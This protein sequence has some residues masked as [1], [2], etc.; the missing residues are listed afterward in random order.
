MNTNAYYEIGAS[1]KVCEDYALSG[2]HDQLYYAIVSDGCSSS[3][4]SDVGARLLAHITKGVLVYMYEDKSILSPNFTEL[5]KELV[6]K[7]CMEAKK[8]LG[9][10]I[11]AFDATLLINFVLGDKVF[12]LS[13]GD[14]YIIYVTDS[15]N[16]IV[17][18][19][20]FSSGAPYYLSYEMC[21]AKKDAYIDAFGGGTIT[22]SQFILDQNN[23]VLSAVSTDSALNYSHTVYKEVAANLMKFVALSSDG[24][25]TYQ[26]DPRFETPDRSK[27]GY[28]AVEM[29]PDIVAYKNITGDFVLRRMRRVKELVEKNHIIHQDDIS[30][31]TIAITKEE[32][33]NA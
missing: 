32:P 20:S 22:V 8:A 33:D 9:L 11:N 1:H 12:S 18:E 24:I 7:K 21:Q 5:F 25:N 10:S 17:Y 26:D 6:L 3:K 31:A 13:W 19:I 2:Q 23:N 30:C 28:S 14:G 29:I 4:D 15:M 27:R 16:I